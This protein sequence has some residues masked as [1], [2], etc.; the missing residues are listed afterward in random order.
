MNLQHTEES[1]RQADELFTLISTVRH[2]EEMNVN[3]GV[4]FAFEKTPGCL[5]C[6]SVRH[7]LHSTEKGGPLAYPEGFAPYFGCT[8]KE[9][10]SII[11]HRHI[12]GDDWNDNPKTTGENYYQAGKELLE[13]YGYGHLFES[14]KPKAMSFKGLMEEM[15]EVAHA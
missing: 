12:R 14:I 2:V 9:A 11:F 8:E 6:E 15:K 13:K 4:V 7:H 5:L 1:N 10:D 3:H